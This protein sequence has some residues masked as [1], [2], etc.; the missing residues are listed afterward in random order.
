MVGLFEQGQPDLCV[1]DVSDNQAW[2]GLA[3]GK[4]VRRIYEKLPIV[5]LTN[6]G[7]EEFA[8][9]ALRA[10]MSDYLKEP[11]GLEELRASIGRCLCDPQS[12]GEIHTPQPHSTDPFAEILVGESETIKDI[13]SYLGKV[14]ATASNVLITGE[15]GTGKELVA[16]IIHENS[17]RRNKPFICVN[18]AAIPDTLL[19]SE[20]F[21][22]ERGAFTGAVGVQKGKME[23]A[24][25]GTIL[26]DEIGDMSLSAQA[27]ILR[28]IEDRT[29]YRLG[30]KTGIDLNLR[31]IAATNQNP[32]KAVMEGTF[33]KDLYYRLN[34]ARIHL[35]PIRERREDIPLLLHHYLQEFNQIFRRQVEGFTNE[36]K[37]FLFEY[38]W[39]GNVR[40]L[41]NLVEATFINLPSKP[42]FLLDLPPQF[43]ARVKKYENVPT[44]ERDR[45]LAALLT[46]NWNRNK[47]A[48]KLQC[49]RMTLYR[50]MLKYEVCNGETSKSNGKKMI[51]QQFKSAV[52]S[53]PAG[54][55]SM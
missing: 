31:I 25:G 34:V 47:A 49:S 54:V 53:L 13:R 41:K 38:S 8:L 14:S 52:T 10:G 12:Q 21:G 36:A 6:E 35:P 2:H 39:P 9:A 43:R 27:K 30:G 3:V 37:N 33:R 51:N 50:K 42:I 22:F 7:S 55:S 44:N 17:S 20:L 48:D 16:R 28:A 5:I 46:T 19:E 1:V 26:F 32:E 45:I 18:C 11:F 40:E 24:Q 15:T 4:E 29:I 23:L